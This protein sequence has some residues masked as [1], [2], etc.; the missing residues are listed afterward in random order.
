MVLAEALVST[1]LSHL[2]LEDAHLGAADI[3]HL[4]EVS[5]AQS[6]VFASEQK[7]N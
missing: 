6:R 3:D 7:Q 4:A 1:S 2:V 5:R